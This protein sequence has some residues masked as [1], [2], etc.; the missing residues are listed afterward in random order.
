MKRISSYKLIKKVPYDLLGNTYLFCM[1]QKNK[2]N[3]RKG[4]KKV[5]LYLNKETKTKSF[6]SYMKSYRLNLISF[7]YGSLPIKKFKKYR[8]NES[9]GLT[10]NK[11]S[12]IEVRLDNMLYRFLLNQTH[13]SCRQYISHGYILIN[14]RRIK[15]PSY[16]VNSGD[17]IEISPKYYSVIKSN[18]QNSFK[19]WIVLK[20]NP[21][22]LECNY[23]LLYGI[24]LNKPNVLE[25]PF[26]IKIK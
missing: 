18:I 2:T 12:M 17:I 6:D 10:A 3:F 13:Y 1:L 23:K 11:I 26:H 7:N 16:A 5:K 25:I 19:N 8:I 21:K 14:G 9:I 15:Q 24:F 22:Y 4:L 20:N